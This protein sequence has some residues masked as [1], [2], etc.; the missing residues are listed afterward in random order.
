M[1]PEKCTG[2]LACFNECEFNAIEIKQNNKGFYIPVINKN[3][4]K[5]CGMCEKVCPEIEHVNKNNVIGCYAAWSKNDEIRK[6]STSGGI[7]YEIAK[8]IIDDGGIVVGAVFDENYKVIHDIIDNVDE[9][10]RLQGS[11]YV[12]SYL[13][14]IY[15]RVEK[16]LLKQRKVVFSGVACQ[17]AGLKNFLKKEYDNLILIDVLCHGAPSPL[18]FNEYLERKKNIGTIK[19]ISFRYKKPSWTVFSMRVDY[20]EN[21]IYQK[22]TFEDEYIR[23]FL[24]D[25]IT[26]EVC[27]ECKYTGEKRVSDL[28]LAD[29]WG[30]VSDKR[31]Y[32]N[33]EKGIS[34]ILTNTEKGFKLLENIE[35][36]LTIVEKDF[37]E[38]QNGNQCLKRP[39]KKNALYKEFWNDYAQNGYE[40]VLNTYFKKKKM[41]MKRKISL[42][43]YNNAYLIPKIVRAKLIKA[44]NKIVEKRF[45]K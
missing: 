33:T 39:F 35:K 26:N 12:Q 45:E 16:E 21:K 31:K 34:M 2:C 44:R 1:L 28:T 15:K 17:I 30:Y 8:S 41:S 37:E 11:K 29:F 23:L 19:N 4:C 38:A 7:F 43:V 42:L 24:D 40:Y 25:Y 32:R 9:L 18:I 36:N 27:A 22:D 10:I 5:N 3:L 14:N 6:K 20:Y 13:G